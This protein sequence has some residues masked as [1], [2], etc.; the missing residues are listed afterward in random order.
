MDIWNILEIEPTHNLNKIRQAYANKLKITRPDDNPEKFQILYFAYKDA[1]H[2]ARILEE[3]IKNLNTEVFRKSEHIEDD[4]D[5]AEANSEKVINHE[6]PEIN[7]L[8]NQSRLLF[9]TNGTQRIPKSW[10]FL[11]DSPYILDNSFNWNLG[12]EILKL[13]QEKYTEHDLSKQIG[14]ESLNYLNSIFNWHDNKKKTIFILGN[15]YAHWFEKLNNQINEINNPL[16]LIRG[17]KKITLNFAGPISAHVTIRLIAWL[18]DIGLIISSVFMLS[19]ITSI[20]FDFNIPLTYRNFIFILV[21]FLYFWL[22][23]S[24]CLQATI[25]KIIFS[26]KVVT[27]QNEKITIWQGLARSGIFTSSILY[28]TCVLTFV[29]DNEKLIAL[30]IPFSFAINLATSILYDTIVD[31]TSNTKVIKS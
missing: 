16:S 9:E 10:K 17:S 28:K 5:P 2:E 22:F 25:G 7:R 8:L 23:E 30:I 3:D 15:S 31:S 1:L 19:A 14:I 13:I 26:I 4:L 11:F 20:L 6:Q 21:M 24:S 18:T 27:E 12:I 29:I